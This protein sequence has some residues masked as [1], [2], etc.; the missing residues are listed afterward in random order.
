M[1]KYDKLVCTVVNHGLGE[2]IAADTI[3]AGA[4]GGTIL[5]GKGSSDSALLRFLSIADVEKDILLTLITNDQLQVVTEALVNSHHLGKYPCGYL[6][7]IDLGGKIMNKVYDHELI[8]IIVNRGYADDIVNAA[9][10]AG[11]TGGTILHARGTGKPGD[12]KFFGITIVPEKEQVLILAKKNI[13]ENI[14]K[15]VLELECLNTPGIGI[16]FVTPASDFVQL[17]KKS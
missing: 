10:K 11:A 5:V 6:F 16:M 8:N 17:G 1:I 15:A 2:K 4:G 7:V 12:E 13:S 3:Q 14:Q 9:R